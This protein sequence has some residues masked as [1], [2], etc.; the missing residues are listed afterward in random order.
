[1]SK[2]GSWI[3]HTLS[4]LCFKI[5]GSSYQRLADKT[6]I[7]KDDDLSRPSTRGKAKQ[8]G[9]PEE[10]SPMLNWDFIKYISSSG[11]RS[12]SDLHLE[13]DDECEKGTS[14]VELNQKELP[15]YKPT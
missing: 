9:L 15:V 4:K 7:L 3:D 11:L 6:C 2:S 14:R 13:V 1:M 12:R 10:A 8:L 5:S